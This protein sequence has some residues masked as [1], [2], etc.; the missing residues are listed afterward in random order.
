MHGSEVVEVATGFRRLRYL[1]MAGGA[2]ALTLVGLVVP[3]IPTVPF[4]LATSY[5]LARSSPRLNDRLRRT[6][7]FGTI[8]VEWEEHHGLSA[9]SKAKLIGLTAAIVAVTVA[10]S[11]GSPVVL[12]VI[13]IIAIVSAYGIVRIP[14]L[15]DLAAGAHGPARLALPSP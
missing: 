12:L 14:G 2:F 4:L 10:L 3:G 13:M 9:Y 1:A 6:A 5:Y 11:A 8:L 7:I 15:P